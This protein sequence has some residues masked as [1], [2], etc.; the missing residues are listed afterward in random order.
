MQINIADQPKPSRL[1]SMGILD[2][3]YHSGALYPRWLL[4]L[5]TMLGPQGGTVDQVI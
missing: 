2:G 4:L 1:I 3:R 5:V